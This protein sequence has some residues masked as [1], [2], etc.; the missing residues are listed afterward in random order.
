VTAAERRLFGSDVAFVGAVYYPTKDPDL[1]HSRA[2]LLRAVHARHDLKIWGLQRHRRELTRGLR[3]IEWPAYNRDLVRICR[4]SR[5]VLGLNKVNTVERYFSNRTFL[6][7]A[8]GGFHLTHY[9]PGLETMFRNH[10][11][12]V[13]FHSTSECLDLI[14]HY[15]ARPAQA[16]AI[17]ERGRTFVRRR[18]GMVRQ[19]RRML[20]LANLLPGRPWDS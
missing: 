13:W 20:G 19:V 10:E 3:T 7:L 6:T 4:S 14:D 9:V 15:L 1:F 5:I 17:A 8:S 18:F 12:L 11:H 2:R 16:A